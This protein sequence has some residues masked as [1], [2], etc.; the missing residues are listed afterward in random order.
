VHL[1]ARIRRSLAGDAGFG[2]ALKKVFAFYP[3]HAAAALAGAATVVIAA[4]LLS[5][6]LWANLGDP[7]AYQANALI[8]GRIICADCALMQKTRTAAPH[9]PSH[10]LVIQT[11]EGKI[12]TIVLSPTGQEL[13]QRTNI[14]AQLVQARGFAFPRVGYVQVTDFEISQN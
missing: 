12:W 4:T 9:A 6:R 13:L 7:I 2:D 10:H 8:S 14:A 5:A 11:Q 1:R 3:G